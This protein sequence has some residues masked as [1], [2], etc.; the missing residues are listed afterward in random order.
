MDTTEGGDL[1]EDSTTPN[2]EINNEPQTCSSLTRIEISTDLTVQQFILEIK[3]WKET[4]STSP[5]GR[6]LGHYKAIIGDTTLAQI[7]TTMTAL[8]LKYGVAPKR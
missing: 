6:H 8:P 7:F 5:S 1:T 3:I 4:T 2:N